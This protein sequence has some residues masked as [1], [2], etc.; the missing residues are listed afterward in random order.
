[1]NSIFKNKE[2]KIYLAYI[3]VCILWGSTYLAIR[4]GVGEFPPTLFAGIRF[5]SAGALMLAFSVYRGLK[6]PKNFSEVMKISVVGLFL[7]LGGNGCVVWAETRISSGV[8]S[9]LVATV[10]LFM[11]LIELVLPDRPRLNFKGWTGLLIGFGGVALLVF[12]N[13]KGNSADV[14]GI[15]LLL[16][17]A[18]SWAMGSVYSKSFKATSSIIP[19]IA[20]QM[21]AGGLGLFIAGTIFGELPKLHVT[22]K[23]MG[24]MLYL[25]IFGS[26]VGYSCY[27]YILDKW[28]AAKAGTYAYVNP[29]VAVLL[30]ALVLGE[31]L[32]LGV[33]MSTAVIL[34]GVIL[35][36]TSKTKNNKKS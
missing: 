5:L 11:A 29:L 34:G 15:V 21:L 23:G 36:Q 27:V 19:N 32:S 16:I 26:I 3:A 6:L 10:P 9:L 31:P 24:A 17:G 35:V 30:G 1:M 2:S 4:I 7:L 22:P 28:P 33:I 20:I 25:I 12:P 14:F 13:S 18:F 8:A